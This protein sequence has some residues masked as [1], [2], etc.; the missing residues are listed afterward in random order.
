MSEDTTNTNAA[1]SKTGVIADLMA[2]IKAAFESMEYTRDEIAQAQRRHPDAADTIW[3]SFSLLTPVHPLMHTSEPLYRAYCR[4][5][6]D[7]VAAGDDT[8]PG[9]A[10]EICCVASE[11]SAVAPLSSPAFGVYAR[12]FR[13]VFPDRRFLGN[14]VDCAYMEHVEALHGHAIDEL[15]ADSRRRLTRAERTLSAIECGGL[16]DGE[17]VECRYRPAEDGLFVA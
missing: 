1:T 6:L 16:H 8:R 17:P 4:E 14:E 11:A 5:I 15:E 13:V 2:E 10:A 9:T 3:H 7:R 12:A